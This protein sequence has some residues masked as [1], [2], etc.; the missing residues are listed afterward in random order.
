M[1]S[2]TFKF[3]SKLCVI[4]LYMAIAVDSKTA[5]VPISGQPGFTIIGLRVRTTNAAEATPQ[6]QIGK[7]WQRISSDS[8]LGQIPGRADSN[9]YAVYTDYDTDENGAYTFVLGV[10]VT[11]GTSPKSNLVSQQVRPGRYALFE[12]K[13]GPAKDVGI[14]TWKRIWSWPDRGKRAYKTDYEVHSAKP[15]SQNE[16]V[17]IYIGVK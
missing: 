13:P 17:R 10:K 5:N 12:S 8:I 1:L 9:I 6:G 2:N 15:G 7:L 3:F 14:E 4:G 11:P 16:Q